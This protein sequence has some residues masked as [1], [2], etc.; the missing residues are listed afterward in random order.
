MLKVIITFKAASHERYV[1]TSN[2]MCPE[3]GSESVG[4]GRLELEHVQSVV[5]PRAAR[6]RDSTFLN[7]GHRNKDPFEKLKEKKLPN[8]E[9]LD[10]RA[11]VLHVLPK[12][13]RRLSAR[14]S[15]LW[16]SELSNTRFLNRGVWDRA[17]SVGRRARRETRFRGA[18]LC[19][20]F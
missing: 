17:R 7:R 16:H 5:H 6:G 19:E 15:T 2:C 3:K 14:L 10:V 4:R 11:Q 20:F 1:D 8:T 18:F 12:G 9:S 13:H